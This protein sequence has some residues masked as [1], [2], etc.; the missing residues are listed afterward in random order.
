MFSKLQGLIQYYF[1][2]NFRCNLAHNDGENCFDSSLHHL[3]KSENFRFT[4]SYKIVGNLLDKLR[5]V[6]MNRT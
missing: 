6:Y 2:E 5:K 1:P 3:F 4:F